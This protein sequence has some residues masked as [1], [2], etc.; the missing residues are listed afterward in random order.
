MKEDS[1]NHSYLLRFI[2]GFIVVLLV[3]YVIR[4]LAPISH[5]MP[6]HS[7]T[8]LVVHIASFGTHYVSVKDVEVTEP[9]TPDASLFSTDNW[10]NQYS[11]ISVIMDDSDSGIESSEKP[12]QYTESLTS[13]P[14]NDCY[15]ES[16]DYSSDHW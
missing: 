15:K 9:T 6:F 7:L 12:V 13:V 4:F 1:A 5:G 2:K 11:D 8:K 3:E 14:G 10:S 16:M